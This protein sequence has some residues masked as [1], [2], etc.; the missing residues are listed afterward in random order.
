[1]SRVKGNII[2]AGGVIPEDTPS[3]SSRGTPGGRVSHCALFCTEA[4]MCPVLCCVCRTR[5]RPQRTAAFST[6]WQAREWPPRGSLHPGIWLT[7]ADSACIPLCSLWHSGLPLSHAKLAPATGL[8]FLPGKLCSDFSGFCI[9][10]RSKFR[11]HVIVG[12]ASD[13]LY[14]TAPSCLLVTGFSSWPSQQLGCCLI[15]RALRSV[16]LPGQCRAQG[17]GRVSDSAP[18]RPCPRRRWAHT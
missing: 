1:M 11:E 13:T 4:A 8:R 9:S 6:M 2:P 18:Y 17:T 5:W 3:C 14:Q 15:I 12:E 10:L 16:S 7:T